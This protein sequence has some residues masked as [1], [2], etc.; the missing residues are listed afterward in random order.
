MKVTL[1]DVTIYEADG[2]T[3][4]TEQVRNPT[5]NAVERAVRRLDRFRYPFIWLYRR[6][7][8]DREQT[9][10]DF[11]VIGG[12]GEF[13]MDA[14]AEG[15]DLRYYDPPRGADLIAVWRSDQ[16][17]TFEAKYCCPSLDTVLRATRYF[18]EHATLDPSLIWQAQWQS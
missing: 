18:C 10:P 9:T 17:A 16:G 14:M 8:V 1:L 6:S 5:W 12:E 3:W 2:W 4:R 15:T 11:S 7:D 13:A